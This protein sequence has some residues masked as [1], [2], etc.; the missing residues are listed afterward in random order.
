MP[1]NLTVTAPEYCMFV[2]EGESRGADRNQRAGTE[3]ETQKIKMVRTPSLSAWRVITGSCCQSLMKLVAKEGAAPKTLWLFWSPTFQVEKLENVWLKLEL[4]SF[5]VVKLCPATEIMVRHNM[6][7]E[8]QLLLWKWVVWVAW[9]SSHFHNYVGNSWWV[10][11]C[12][13]LPCKLQVAQQL[14]QS[15][16]A[17]RSSMVNLT[18]T[19]VAHGIT[20]Q[21]LDVVVCCSAIHFSLA[22]SNRC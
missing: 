6:F 5:T 1:L 8:M 11:A 15:Q 16:R 18:V 7:Q 3:M 22:I 13:C 21:S 12:W 17:C 14:N 2:F 10:S 20:H 4:F 9:H 19:G